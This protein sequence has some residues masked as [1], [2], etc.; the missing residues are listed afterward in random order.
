MDVAYL[1]VHG[2]AGVEDGEGGGGVDARGDPDG[3][4][5]GAEG[6]QLPRQ[7]RRRHCTEITLYSAPAFTRSH[8]T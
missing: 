6:G 7:R 8:I 2:L 4:G 5:G 1:D 3:G